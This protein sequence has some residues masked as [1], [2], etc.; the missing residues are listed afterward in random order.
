MG[1]ICV[2]MVMM[3]RNQWYI[4]L[5]SSEVKQGKPVGVTRM[6]EKL[7]LWRDAEGKVVCMKDQ[8]PHRGVALSCGKLIDGLIE[9]PFHGFQFDGSGRCTLIPANGR[10]APVPRRFRP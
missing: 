3:I 9:C 6:G 7:V 4:I 2:W 10:N 5:E 8:C 1:E